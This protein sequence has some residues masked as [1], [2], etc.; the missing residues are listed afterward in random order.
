MQ[1]SAGVGYPAQVSPRA[2]L[3]LLLLVAC[4]G[5][6]ATSATDSDAG[7]SSTA[8]T[9]SSGSSGDGASGSTSDVTTSTGTS[10]SPT[11]AAT[12]VTGGSTTEDPALA[13]NGHPALCSRR[14]DEV[15][16]PCT[17]NS[18]SS[19]DAGFTQLVANQRR[20]VAVQLADGVRA[21][22]LD[23]RLDDG[24]TALCHGSCMYGK[25][26]HVEVLADVAAFLA[27][28]P[29]EVVTILY[30]DSADVEAIAADYAA[31]ALEDEVFVYEGGPFPTLEE[32]IAADTRLVV[33]AEQG[34]PPPAWYHHLWDVA[35]DTPY[36]YMSP[37][38]F[39][40]A[41]NRGDPDNPLFLV[42]HWVNSVLDLPSEMNAIEVN[43]Y[44]VLH[45]RVVECMQASADF[46]N[47]VAVDYYERGDLFAVVDAINGV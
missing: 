24:A 25:T 19:Q 33:T 14:Y 45:A 13:C 16:Y 20:T 1:R 34:G 46:P 29:R 47:F 30:E 10:G 15:A 22:M 38:E 28:N 26:P 7:E 32:M 39:S 21:L 23:V 6:P 35:W 43:T 37:D 41:P 3:A 2:P 17:H 44:E 4:P 27:D 42:N 8:S 12:E 5:E 18:Y 40:C 31:L 36:S 11:E 9:T